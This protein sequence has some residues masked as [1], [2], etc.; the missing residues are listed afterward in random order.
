VHET[1]SRET[2]ELVSL[3]DIVRPLVRVV[4]ETVA[5]PEVRIRFTVE[6]EAGLVPGELATPL[7]VVLNELMQNAADHAFPAEPGRLVTGSVVITLARRD[8]RLLVDVTDDGIGLP[9]GFSLGESAGLGIS[10]VETLVTTELG[11]SIAM[12]AEGGTRVRLRIP[13]TGRAVAGG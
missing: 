6:G 7:A 12:S 10:I 13:L 2:S 1:L 8:D 3:D 5:S 4:E 9:A 11:G